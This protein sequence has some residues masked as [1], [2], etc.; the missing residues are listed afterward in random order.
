[1]QNRLLKLLLLITSV[2]VVISCCKKTF[3]DFYFNS[4]DIEVINTY[5]Y[6]DIGDDV[7]VSQEGYLI[8][9]KLNDT[10][11]EAIDDINSLRKSL[12]YCED[13]EVAL[14][15]DISGLTLSCNN[16]IWNTPVGSPLDLNN[17]RIFEHDM[18]SD[19]EP[20]YMTV[21]DWM[22]FINSKTQFVDFEWYLA[23][24]E[25]IISPDFL[26]FTLTFETVYRATYQTETKAVKLE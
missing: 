21:Q 20:K 26:K 16:T 6:R 13:N 1:M 24:T 7:T 2:L 12:D 9:L 4:N 3:D 25:P 22:Q 11:K 10:T 8:K 5:N 23:F 18:D 14:K 15:R 17:I 19:L